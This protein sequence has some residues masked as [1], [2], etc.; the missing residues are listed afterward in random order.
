MKRP[1][2]LTTRVTNDLRADL[3]KAASALGISVNRFVVLAITKEIE[4]VQGAFGELP[5]VDE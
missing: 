5:E 1:N 2:P 4:Y 3:K